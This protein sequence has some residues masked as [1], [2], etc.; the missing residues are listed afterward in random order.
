MGSEEKAQ[1]RATSPK[2]RAYAEAIVS[3]RFSSHVAAWRTV[4]G[5]GKATPKT[6]RSEASKALKRPGMAPLL[7]SLRRAA[8]R[9]QARGRAATRRYVERSLYAEA[10]N[11]DDGSAAT[12]LR[13]LELLG[14]WSQMWVE[15]SAVAVHAGPLPQNAADTMAEIE[16]ILGRLGKP[17]AQPGPAT[18]QSDPEKS[19]PPE[20]A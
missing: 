18:A 3:G 11:R 13:A 14:K 1:K 17:E 9:D 20:K 5:T 12:R 8:E 2:Q 16:S 15:R 19:L 7:E 4:Y 6:E 10:E